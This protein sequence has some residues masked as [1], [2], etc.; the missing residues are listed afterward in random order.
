MFAQE[1][2]AFFVLP[3][4]Q[5]QHLYLIFSEQEG[6]GWIFVRK[7]I[8]EK[9]GHGFRD[10]NFMCYEGHQMGWNGNYFAS[11]LLSYFIE[12]PNLG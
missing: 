1:T 6:G 12:Q 4:S 5:Y 8:F 11:L 10:T 9:H 7:Q 3:C 2:L